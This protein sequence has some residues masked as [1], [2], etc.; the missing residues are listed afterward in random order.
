MVSL[1]VKQVQAI[2]IKDAFTFIHSLG[3]N[4]TSGSFE[5]RTESNLFRLFQPGHFKSYQIT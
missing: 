3:N 4:V 5:L 2:Q 1:G